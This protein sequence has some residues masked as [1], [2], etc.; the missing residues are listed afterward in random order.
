MKAVLIG[1]YGVG[2]FGDEALR[3]YFLTAYPE[4]AWTV[5][6]ARPGTDELPRLPIGVRSFFGTSWWKTVTAI[7]GSDAVVFGGGTLFT[8]IE[9]VRACV[10]WGV[11]AFVARFFRVPVHLAFQGVGPFKTALGEGIARR[12][13]RCARF[14]SVRDAAS[15]ARVRPWRADVIETFDPIFLLFLQRRK[16]RLPDSGILLIPRHNSGEAFLRACDAVPAN[17]SVTIALFQ[18]NRVGEANMADL[19][20]A[21]FPCSTVR[22]IEDADTLMDMLSHAERCVCERFHGALAAAAAGVPT[23]VV[24]RAAG[25][26]LDEVR[27]LFEPGAADAARSLAEAGEV[28]LRTALAT[29]A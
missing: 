20:Q 5:L 28:S 18:S 2:N 24:T 27:A 21:R 7:R 26:K 3:E 15:L 14:V 25:D 23:V 4:V 11:H 8:D 12:V 13:L 19:L 6:S 22:S 17:V 29:A 1:N 16:L 9:S 10:L